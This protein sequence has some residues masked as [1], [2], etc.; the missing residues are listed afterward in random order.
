MA[1]LRVGLVAGETSGDRLGAVLIRA[2]RTRV[3]EL[4]VVGVAGAAMRAAGCQAIA[5]V[6]ALSLMGLMEIVTHLPRLLILRRRL[7]NELTRVQP[8]LVVGI[9]APDFNLGLERRLRKRGFRTAHYVSPSVWAWRA[10]RVRSVARAAEAVLCLLPFEP[11]CYAAVPVKASFVGHPLV[12]EIVPVSVA[13]ARRTLRLDGNGRILAVLPGSRVGEV[14]RLAP[15]FFA[16]ADA[17]TRSHPDLRIVVPLARPL[18]RAPVEAALARHPG[19]SATLFDADAR[20]AMGAADAVL[21]ASGTAAL[22][23]LLL[24]RPMVVAYRVHVLTAWLLR[25]AGLRMRYFSLPNLL[26]ESELVPELIQGSAS[27]ARITAAVAELLDNAEARQK[28]RDGFAA[29]R[30]VLGH[31]AADRAA[32][33]LL[34]LLGSGER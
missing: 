27:V 8:D 34:A 21:T 13:D 20:S 6:D 2:L 19:L 1:S 26:A 33:A 28:Q 17:L 11:A 25:H 16:A 18:L 15:L 9:D 3:P 14:K 29:V 10:G 32:D 24:N 30:A 22:E 12:D 4:E 5:D 31:Y 7:L 23:A